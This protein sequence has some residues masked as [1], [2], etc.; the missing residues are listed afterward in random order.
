MAFIEF[1][2]DRD[3][4]RALAFQAI[5][6]I[7]KALESGATRTDLLKE[8]M[9]L[10]DSSRQGSMEYVFHSVIVVELEEPGYLTLVGQQLQ[11]L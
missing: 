9:K 3:P 5:E 11:Y 1:A 8:Q 10:L 4:K 2:R 7:Q 6:L